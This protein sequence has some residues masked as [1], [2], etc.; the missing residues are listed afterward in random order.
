LAKDKLIDFFKSW[1]SFILAKNVFVRFIKTDTD[2]AKPTGFCLVL[3]AGSSL[4]ALISVRL[5]FFRTD[6]ATK[7]QAIVSLRE[8]LDSIGDL[9][10]V[11]TKPL[12]HLMEVICNNA[13]ATVL[14]ET[15]LVDNNIISM[16]TVDPAVA[17]AMRY[18]RK[19]TWSFFDEKDISTLTLPGKLSPVILAQRMIRAKR[20][21]QGFV[22]VSDSS[23]EEHIVF[24]RELA[25]G[26]SI[27]DNCSAR[28]S[29]SILTR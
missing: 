15:R 2:V 7:Q 1:C 3:L 14:N 8:A 12:S 9:V 27:Y 29:F 16:A 21:E 13:T 10:I 24:Y 6:V 18:L 26:G 23:S 28:F 11:C 25:V 22:V 4:E 20:L 5:A 19:T 17:I